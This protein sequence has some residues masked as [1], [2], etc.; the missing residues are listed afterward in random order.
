MTTTLPRTTPEAQ[1]IPAVVIAEFVARAASTLHSLHSFMLLR[2]GAV[3][4]EGWWHPYRP[5]VPHMLYSLSKSFT[6]TAVGLAVSEGRL[7][8]DDAVLKFFP[9]EAPRRVSRNLRAMKVRHLL[10]MS[11]GHDLDTTERMMPRR[12]PVRAFLALPVEHEPGT[13]FVYNS[14]ASFMLAAIVQ[15]LTGQTLLEYLTPRL[16]A[17]L[18]IEGAAWESHPSGVNFGG[19]GL[20]IKTEDIARFGQ[21][22]LQKGRWNGQQVLPASWVETATSPQVPNGNDPNSDWC[23]GYGYQFW[24]CRHKA[25]RGDGAFGQFCIVMPDQDAVL[26]ITSGVP[27]MQPVLNAVWETILPAMAPQALPPDE[28]ADRALEQTLKGLHLAPPQG[29]APSPLAALIAGRTFT[30]EPNA[31]ALKWLSLEFGP[32]G[33]ALTCRVLSSRERRDAH[34]IGIGGGSRRPGAHTIAFGYGRWVEGLDTSRLP[35]PRHIVAS[36]V[37]TADDTFT[38]TVCAYETP[39]TA[40]L[41]LCFTENKVTYQSRVNVALGPTVSPPVVGVV[42][43]GRQPGRAQRPRLAS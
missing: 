11:T 31:E 21:L 5:E 12:N 39:V 29:A 41:T 37:W 30:C 22:Y 14:G 43:S 1:G 18:G 26:A 8:A 15:S 40:T 33:G 10:S 9:A 19:W 23:Q 25:Y 3:A 24:R 28:P 32:E 16:F 27:D 2:H 13:H 38:L 17:P 20:D 7:D 35:E 34:T 6:S 4:A 36:G 42:G